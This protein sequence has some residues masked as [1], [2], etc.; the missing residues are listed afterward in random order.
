MKYMYHYTC[1]INFNFPQYVLIAIIFRSFNNSFS[2]PNMT[3]N[4]PSFIAFG[5]VNQSFIQILTIS[6][7]LLYDTNGKHLYTIYYYRDFEHSK[8]DLRV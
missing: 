1:N 4:K 2:I 6:I 3:D 8:L 5:I 7:F